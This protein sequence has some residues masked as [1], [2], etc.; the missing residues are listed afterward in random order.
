MNRQTCQIGGLFPKTP[1][2]DSKVTIH[3]MRR[4][5]NERILRGCKFNDFLTY[6]RNNSYYTQFLSM[7]NK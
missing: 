6:L 3:K 2:N 7:V 4:A 1:R 5:P